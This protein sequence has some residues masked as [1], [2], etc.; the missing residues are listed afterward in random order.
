V[1]VQFSFANH[2]LVERNSMAF[3]IWYN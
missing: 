1:R 3:T 2:L